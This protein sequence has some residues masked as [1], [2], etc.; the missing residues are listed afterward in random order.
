MRFFLH[1]KKDLALKKNEQQKNPKGK[2]D[3]Q[4]QQISDKEYLINRKEQ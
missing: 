3:L 1:F 2:G 4:N